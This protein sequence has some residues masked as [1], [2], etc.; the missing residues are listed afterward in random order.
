MLRQLPD[1][2]RSLYLRLSV[3]DRCDFRCQYCRPERAAGGAA[4]CN[5]ASNAELLELVRQIDRVRPVA[6]LRLT[7]G[8]PLLR[9]GL[10]DLTRD[11]R[12]LLPDAAL[13]LTTNGS[14][15]AQLAAPLRAAGVDALNVSL[16][17]L[18][19]AAFARLTRGGR[20]DDVLA[21][22]EA[23]RSVGFSKLKL[24]SV[25]IRGV[26]GGTLGDLVRFSAERG[27]EI[28]FI[29]LMPCGP[30]ADLFAIDRL[31]ADEALSSLKLEFPYVEELPQDGTAQRHRFLVEGRETTIGM[32]S[33]VSHPFCAAC[34][35]LRMDCRGR[36]VSC[37]RKP[38]S[39][40]LLTPLRSGYLEEVERRIRDCLASKSSPGDVWPERQMVLIG[41]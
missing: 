36:L 23:A 14:R 4:S 13:A 30:G 29:E 12:A 19:P 5:A 39:E 20:L 17:T 3:T 18:D 1:I 11:L 40:D 8:E 27:C 31:T 2:R 28:R 41:G 15:L 32:I 6:K 38:Q 24:N 26:N 9:S 35:R 16:D 25:L 7:G 22:I 21:G 34:N 37:L 10:V 33:P